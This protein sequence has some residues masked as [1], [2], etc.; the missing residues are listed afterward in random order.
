MPIY[1]YQCKDEHSFDKILTI[2]AVDSTKVHC[3]ECNKIGKR[4]IASAFDHNPSMTK[5]HIPRTPRQRFT[6]W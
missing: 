4:V 3:P 6:N 1:A 2:A 5:K